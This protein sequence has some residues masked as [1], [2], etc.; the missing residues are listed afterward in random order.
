M[1]KMHKYFSDNFVRPSPSFDGLMEE[2]FK[3]EGY[4][5]SAILTHDG[6][7]LHDTTPSGTPGKFS[8][9]MQVF[10]TLFDRTCNLSEASGFLACQKVSMRTGDEIVIIHGTGQNCQNGLRLLVIINHQGNEAMI[11]RKL[12]TLLPPIMSHLTTEPN[13]LANTSKHHESRR[14]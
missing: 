1:E 3:I 12:D 7:V 4:K 2:L 5:A 10:N 6:E 8:A 14:D 11:Q 13:N 9:W